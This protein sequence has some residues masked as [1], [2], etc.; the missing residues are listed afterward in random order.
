MRGVSPPRGDE[1][2]KQAGKRYNLLPLG[3]FQCPW[4][5]RHLSRDAA[6]ELQERIG[7]PALFPCERPEEWW[8]PPIREEALRDLAVSDLPD[9]RQVVFVPAVLKFGSVLEDEWKTISAAARIAR[10]PLLRHAY[11]VALEMFR[12][13]QLVGVETLT[14]MHDNERA[15]AAGTWNTHP[16]F[17]LP[18]EDVGLADRIF[19]YGR[20]LYVSR[21]ASPEEFEA[22]AKRIRSCVPMGMAI[23][24]IMSATG[25]TE[26]AVD[27]AVH[28]TGDGAPKAPADQD[29]STKRG[30]KKSRKA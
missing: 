13:W 29:G 9:G 7:E 30:A 25:Y 3:R 11:Q 8:P 1:I 18:I 22:C 19:L 23:K 28:H 5:R 4:H 2:R 27:F 24:A 15:I 21:D 26:Q 10:P 20:E 16:A 12:R 6:R 14:A 17:S